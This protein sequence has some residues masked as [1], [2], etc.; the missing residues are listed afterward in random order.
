MPRRDLL[1]NPIWRGETLGRPIPD[2]PHAV[3][4]ALPR[5]QDV[6]GYEG[7]R[8]EVMGRLAGG[9]PRFVIHPLVQALAR[10]LGGAGPCLPFPS[11]RAAESGQEFIRRSSGEAA[12]IV[13]G[14]GVHG[15]V[16]SEAVRPLLK[17]FW[18]HVGL[19]VSSR[20]AEA[21]LSG[22]QDGDGDTDARVSLAIRCS[23][24]FD[25]DGVQLG[26]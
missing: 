3:S 8:P 17:A 6:V 22:R 19:I 14:L 24:R 12:R 16:T 9:Y 5:W 4:V 15:V 13:S 7:G 2:S 18:Q 10:R 1:A 23:R 11:R 21:A 26:P 20:R 25:V